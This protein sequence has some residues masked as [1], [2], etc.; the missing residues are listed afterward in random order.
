M[1]N[2]KSCLPMFALNQLRLAG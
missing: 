1:S 2:T